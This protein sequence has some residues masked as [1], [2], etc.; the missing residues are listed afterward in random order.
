[1]SQDFFDDSGFGD[2]GN[3]AELTAAVWTNERVGEVDPPDELSPSLAK[4]GTLLWREV[5][6]VLGHGGSVGAERLKGRGGQTCSSRMI[7]RTRM[8]C[9]AIFQTIVSLASDNG[10]SYV[11]RI[12]SRIL[13]TVSRLDRAIIR[14][15]ATRADVSS[16]AKKIKKRLALRDHFKRL[17]FMVLRIGR[18]PNDL[19]WIL[20]DGRLPHDA[21]SITK[22]GEPA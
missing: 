3:D 15:L 9:F 17:Q 11:R 12:P 16:A 10:P 14:L 5:G 20:S 7:S 2:E 21:N 8:S 19:E 13:G 4:S 22:R 18:A 1:M 6:F